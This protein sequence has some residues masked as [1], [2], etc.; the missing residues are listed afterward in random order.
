MKNF[1]NSHFNTADAVFLIEVAW[2]EVSVR[3]LHLPWRPLWCDNVAPRD[4]E[5]F[6]QLEVEPVMQEIVCL[7]SSMGLEMNEEDMEELVVNHRKKLSFE[8]VTELHNE[9]AEALKQWIAYKDEDKEKSCSIPAEDLREVFSCQNK[10]SKLTKNYHQ[11]TVAV[12]MGLN[13]F[14]DTLMIHF[15]RVQKYMIKVRPHRTRS[16]AADCGQS[17]LR[18]TFELYYI[19]LHH[20]CQ[21]ECGLPQRTSLDRSGL[22]PVVCCRQ[23][24]LADSTAWRKN[25]SIDLCTGGFNLLSHA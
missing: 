20:P 19:R 22:R 16:A 3:C 8:V 14:N 1:W 15:W 12:E 21:T 10:L 23:I 2:K 17:P 5:G 6:Q 4:F 25:C 9:E 7:G 18:Q 11:H 13:Y 24:C